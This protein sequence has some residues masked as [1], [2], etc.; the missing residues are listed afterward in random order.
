VSGER[1]SKQR[2]RLG[3]VIS[4]CCSVDEVRFVLKLDESTLC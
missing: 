2:G 3:Q 4:I 1:V